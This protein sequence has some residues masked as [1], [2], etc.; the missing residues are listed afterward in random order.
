MMV[1]V[2]YDVAT[3]DRVGQK[4]LHR[5]AKTCENYGI[6]V[7]YSV[8]ECTV[9]SAQW[10]VLKNKLLQTYKEDSDSLRFYYM[11]S[12]WDRKVEHHGVKEVPNVEEDLLM[13]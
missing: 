8:F 2:T 4:R 5:I 12:N 3:G 10:Q 7:Q 9:D 6:R 13:V 1:L 11:G